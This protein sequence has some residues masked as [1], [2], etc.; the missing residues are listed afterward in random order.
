MSNKRKIFWVLVTI[1]LIV[2]LFMGI[3][4]S[5]FGDT[6]GSEVTTSK[7][8]SVTES[9]CV[10]IPDGE[11]ENIQSGM[12]SQKYVLKGLGAVNLTDSNN[13]E[14]KAIL[15]KWDTGYVIAAEISGKELSTPVIGMWGRQ[16][17]AGLL[18]ALNDEALKYSEWG[19]AINEGS[20]AYQVRLK[21][22]RFGTELGVLNC[23]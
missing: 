7:V 11:I 17:N 13:G 4:G 10:N 6:S 3:L 20:P 9:A 18:F 19:T 14:I 12:I 21:L 22:L 2:P 5:L 8:E 23:G 15:P 16:G 1:F